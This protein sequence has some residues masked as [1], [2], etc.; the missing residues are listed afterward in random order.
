MTQFIISE[1]SKKVVYLMLILMISFQNLWAHSI[2]G[3]VKDGKSE[4]SIPYATISLYTTSDSS[5]ITGTVSG[6]DGHFALRQVASGKYNLRVSFMGYQTVNRTIVLTNQEDY[7][8]G[9][10]LL[11]E[12]AV[13]LGEG[14]A[15]AI[16]E[17][18]KA[19]TEPDKTTYFINKKMEDASNTGLDV[20]KY[21][22]GVQLDFSQNLSLEGNQNILLLVDGKERDTGFIRQLDASQIDKVE[23]TTMPGSKYDASVSGV[24]NIILKH[25]ETGINGYVHG[26]I[27]TSQNVVYIFPGYGLNYGGKKFSLQTSYSGQVSNFPIVNNSY[28]EISKPQQTT[29]I[30][31][32]QDV[33]QNNWSHRFNFGIDYFMNKQNQF[34]LYTFYNPY[35]SEHNGTMTLQSQI[36][37]TQDRYWQAKKTDNDRN[38]K[39]F[40]SLYYKHLFHQPNQELTVDASYYYLT[41]HN[42]TTY[43]YDSSSE[44]GASKQTNIVRPRQQNAS[45]KID[46]TTPLTEYFKLET[47][48]KDILKSMTDRQSDSF[49]YRENI[50]A[51]Y[52]SLSFAKNNVQLNAGLRAEHSTNDFIDHFTR[53]FWAWLP[54]ASLNY[55]LSKTKSLKISYRRSIYRPNIYQLNPYVSQNDPFSLQSGNP[56]LKPQFSQDLFLDYSMRL[57]NNFLST[58]LFYNQSTRVINSLTF[59]NDS[60]LFETNIYNA[61]E[62]EQLGLQISSALKLGKTFALNPYLKVFSNWTHPNVIARQYQTVAKQELSYEVGLSAIASFKHDWTAAF[63]MQYYHPTTDIQT[64]RNMS[65]ALYFIS[66]E[67]TIKKK[68]KLGIVSGLPFKRSFAYHGEKTQGPNFYQ[69]SVGSVIL[70][71]VPVWFS[72]R[73]QFSSGKKVHTIQRET[74]K[75]DQIPKKGF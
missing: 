8:A 59:V 3:Q 46:F 56:W 16:G 54:S 26:E 28:R 62:V 36:N 65:D 51:G 10:I 64:I 49:R 19:K 21:V 67:K 74:E 4:Q 63:R 41:A 33:M 45:I 18:I 42:A 53:H 72:I 37:Q 31:S 20:L 5:L 60:N 66:V 47:G 29:T 58:R 32:Q 39:L 27:P 73:Y 2:T 57:G 9:T 40:G 61:G 22:P 34:N 44:G 7:H 68:I 70:P 55:Q 17:R 14:E 23:V 24:I 48:M 13:K 1:K 25:R 38:H 50:L 52:G 6:T 12:I 30:T 71:S 75:L 11:R 69:R 35:S 43:A 15:V